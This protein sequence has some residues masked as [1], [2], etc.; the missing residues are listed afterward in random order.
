M[1]GEEYNARNSALNNFLNSP[2]ISSFLYQ[3]LNMTMRK[4]VLVLFYRYYITNLL[5]F[6]EPGG[7]LP[8]LHKPAI[9]P[10]LQKELSNL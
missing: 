7:S 9:D 5:A 1:L 10:Y 6:K 3:Q 2:I 4:K 8:P